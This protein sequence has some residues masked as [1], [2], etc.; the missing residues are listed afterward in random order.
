MNSFNCFSPA[1]DKITDLYVKVQLI[2]S[3]QEIDDNFNVY[4]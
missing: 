1:M 4:K 3:I 2:I